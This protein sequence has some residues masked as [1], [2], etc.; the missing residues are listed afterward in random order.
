MR[1]A[2]Y[3]APALSD[4]L[5]AAGTAWLGRDPESGARLVQPDVAGIAAATA[6]TRRYG[7]H[8]T[9]KP[10]MRLACGVEALID[11]LRGVLAGVAPF[12][13]PALRISRIDGFIALTE[14]ERSEALQALADLCVTGLERHRVAESAEEMVRRAARLDEHGRALLA[15]YGYGYVLDRW[16]FHMT[17]SERL[18]DGAALEAAARDYFAAALAVPRRVEALAV[19]VEDVPGA[20]FRLVARVG[21]RGEKKSSFLQKRTK[22]LF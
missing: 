11:D 8:A 20:A 6:A 16:Q 14:V 17:L 22:K 18:D 10:P 19:Y 15:R 12:A 3:Y 7:F 4:P 1:A 9:I 21:L 5:W 2:I 13:M